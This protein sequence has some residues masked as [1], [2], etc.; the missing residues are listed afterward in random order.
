LISQA[1]EVPGAVET[2]TVLEATNGFPE[3]V[4]SLLYR[5]LDRYT[6]SLD[7]DELCAF[8]RGRRSRLVL[9]EETRFIPILLARL[10]ELKRRLGDMVAEDALASLFQII[11]NIVG[12]SFKLISVIEYDYPEIIDVLLG[13][14]RDCLILVRPGALVL[15][16]AIAV[17]AIVNLGGTIARRRAVRKHYL[18]LILETGRS[19]AEGPTTTHMAH[20][21]TM[22]E[23]FKPYVIHL[24]VLTPV[25]H[26][27]DRIKARNIEPTRQVQDPLSETKKAIEKNWEEL[28]HYAV[29]R[30]KIL[31]EYRDYSIPQEPA[32]CSYKR[33]RVFDVSFCASS[34]DPRILTSFA[35]TPVSKKSGFFCASMWR[36]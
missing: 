33:V 29:N 15:Y 28:R 7:V 2:I 30:R 35:R 5:C 36:M 19:I 12:E 10:Q 24:S 3:C 4:A 22:L 13:I 34:C 32:L 1:I 25:L 17:D 6:Y 14:W 9:E 21:P 20:L 11:F 31:K 18:E 8:V 23:H 16:C 26:A 27:L